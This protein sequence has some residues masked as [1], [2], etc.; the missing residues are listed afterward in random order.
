MTGR[1]ST[2]L[3]YFELG[4]GAAA[5]AQNLVEQSNDRGWVLAWMLKGYARHFTISFYG[6]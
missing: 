1:S 3:A 2:A 5:L 4:T 6:P